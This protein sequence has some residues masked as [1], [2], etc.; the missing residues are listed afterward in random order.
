MRHV[1]GRCAR[2]YAYLELALKSTRKEQGEDIERSSGGDR[3]CVFEKSDENRYL[4]RQGTA[5][6]RALLLLLSALSDRRVRRQSRKKRVWYTWKSDLLLER[7]E[8]RQR[9]AQ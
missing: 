4:I 2:F 1:F 7:S 3:Q 6:D 8:K 5:Q 9:E